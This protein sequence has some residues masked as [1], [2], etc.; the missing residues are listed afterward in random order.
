MIKELIIYKCIENLTLAKNKKG[1][2]GEATQV[3]PKL[4]NLLSRLFPDTSTP[5]IEED[6]CFTFKKESHEDY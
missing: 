2:G 4:G 5:F 3:S 6:Q 1:C